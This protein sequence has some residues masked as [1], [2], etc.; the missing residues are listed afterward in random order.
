MMSPTRISLILLPLFGACAVA[1]PAAPVQFN[2]QFETTLLVDVGQRCVDSAFEP[3]D[4]QLVIGIEADIRQP[5]DDVGLELGLFHSSQDENKNVGG[6]GRVDFE[7]AMTELSVGAR[8]KYGEWGSH[9]R[10]YA[11]AGI[12]LL[13]ASYSTDPEA[14]SSK[15]SSDWTVGPYVRGGIEWPFGENLSLALDYRQVL[16]TEILNDLSLADSSTDANYSQIGL[17]FGWKF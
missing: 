1:P 15:S 8:W 11:A 5:N 10:P 16:F 6:V 7:S 12:S 4:D 2:S 14:S 17:V 9:L 3:V 13:F